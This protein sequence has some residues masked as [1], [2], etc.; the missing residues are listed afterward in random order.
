MIT[1][2]ASTKFQIVIPRAIRQRQKIKKGDV[3]EF[4]EGDEPNIIVLRKID[5]QQ[6]KGLAALLASC[7]HD[8]EIPSYGREHVRPIKL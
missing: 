4:V 8:F 7:P 6:N 3:F 5:R 2:K 1:A